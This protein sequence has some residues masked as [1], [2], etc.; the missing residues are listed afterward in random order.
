M[1]RSAQTTSL[2]VDIITTVFRVVKN[3]EM[4]EFLKLE[5]IRETGFAHMRIGDG[6]S[7]RLQLSGLLAKLCKAAAKAS[8]GRK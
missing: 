2:A 4:P 6:V 3:Y 7:S 5:F 1:G 8:G